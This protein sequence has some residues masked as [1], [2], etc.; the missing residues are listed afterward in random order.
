MVGEVVLVVL[1]MV[2]EGKREGKREG[3]GKGKQS[4]GGRYERDDIGMV[5]AG[6]GFERE[7]K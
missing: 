1:V 5:M 3:E 6:I 2:G 7:R 4:I